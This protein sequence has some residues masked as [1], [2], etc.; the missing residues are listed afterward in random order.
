MHTNYIRKFKR[1]KNHKFISE[2]I[3]QNHSV[4]VAQV[5]K[6]R[7]YYHKKGLLF[8]LSNLSDYQIS[9]FL[10]AMYVK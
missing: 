5:N 10:K 3:I 2:K 6:K 9:R 8:G 4:V 1:K 7:Y